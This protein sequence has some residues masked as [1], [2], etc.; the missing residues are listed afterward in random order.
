MWVMCGNL[1]T[2]GNT[3]LILNG[4]KCSTYVLQGF[5]NPSTRLTGRPNFVHLW[6]HSIKLASGLPSS[7]KNLEVTPRYLELFCTSDVGYL[8]C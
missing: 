5:T 6:I 8:P 1:V 3:A 2:G 4:R 7:A